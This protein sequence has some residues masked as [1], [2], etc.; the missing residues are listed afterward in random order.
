M[1]KVHKI[2]FSPTGTTKNI[3]A[4]AAAS[5]TSL[6][7]LETA[8]YDFTSP[9]ARKRFPEISAGDLV[10]FAVPTYAGRVPNVLLKY[11]DTVEG[12]GAKTLGMVSFGNRNFDSSLLELCDILNSR[13]FN[14]IAAAA[15]SCQ[16]AFSQTLGK[17]RPDCEDMTQIE[18]FTGK[19]AKK[20]SQ[21]KALRP[22][23]P[24]IAHT[25][26]G[27]YR[28]QDRNGAFIDI[29]KVTPKVSSLCTDCGRCVSICPMGSISS[30]NVRRMTGICIKCNACVK[31]CPS[32]AR[33]FDDSGYLY[34]KEELEE[35]YSR[36]ACNSFFL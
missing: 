30:E 9:A 19:V 7:D 3:C 27:Y 31:H 36:R 6:L 11:L 18:D 4:K 12:N 10:V 32:S 5:L 33:F 21:G 1:N 14:V 35:M 29:R 13:G 24:G 25:Y 2:F 15:I 34:H 22:E 28:P 8:E 20:L 26:G 17:G 23:V 16:H